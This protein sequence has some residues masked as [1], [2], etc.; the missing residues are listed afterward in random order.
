M[1]CPDHPTRQLDYQGR[2]G[3]PGTGWHGVCPVDNRDWA[4]VGDTAHRPEDGAHILTAAD[5]I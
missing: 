4:V 3:A 2:Y 5:V 1:N